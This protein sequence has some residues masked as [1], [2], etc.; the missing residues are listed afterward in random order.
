MHGILIAPEVLISK[1]ILLS[2]NK[3]GEKCKAMEDRRGQV[4]SDTETFRG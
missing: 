2:G 3:M 1:Q 4:R